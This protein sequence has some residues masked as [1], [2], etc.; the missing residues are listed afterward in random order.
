MTFRFRARRFLKKAFW[1]ILFA[2]Y[3]F[4]SR[5]SLFLVVLFLTQ[6]FLLNA[7]FCPSFLSTILRSVLPGNLTFEAIQISPL[8]WHVD[9][10]GLSIKTPDETE[11]ISASQVRVSVNTI[12]LISHLLKRS[13]E[14]LPVVFE[15]VRV[16]DFFVRLVFEKDKGLEF[17]RAFVHQKV[18]KP[19]KRTTQGTGIRMPLKH[20]IAENGSLFLSFPEWDMTLTGIDTETSMLVSDEPKVFIQTS[21]ASFLKGIVRIH[22]AP[23]VKEIPREIEI[24]E[25]RAKGFDFKHDRFTIEHAEI[26]AKGATVMAKGAFAFSEEANLSYEGTVQVDLEPGSPILESAT[27]GLVNGDFHIEVNGKGDAHNPMFLLALHSSH[28]R[29]RDFVLEDLNLTIHGRKDEAKP[30]CFDGL[31]SSFRFAGG[32]VKISDGWICP[33][34]REHGDLSVSATTKVHLE[35]IQLASLLQGH[36]PDMAK[37]IPDQLDASF[38]VEASSQGKDKRLSLSGSFG[39]KSKAKRLF[40]SQDIALRT[41][42]SVEI[43]DKKRSIEIEKFHL[44]SGEDSLTVKGKVDLETLA[45]NLSLELKK[46]LSPVFSFFGQTGRGLISVSNGYISGSIPEPKVSGRLI[47]KGFDFR[48]VR[49]EEAEGKLLATRTYAVVENLR[50]KS[51]FA[52]L[53]AKNLRIDR[54]LTQNPFI[55]ISEMTAHRI[56][57]DYLQKLPMSLKGIFRLQMRSLAFETRNWFKTMRGEGRLTTPSFQVA[58]KGFRSFSLI[59][60]LDK[61]TIGIQRL[62]CALATGGNIRAKGHISLLSKGTD[63]TVD[64]KGVPIGAF[65]DLSELEGEI[66][67]SFRVLGNIQDPE[68][69]ATATLSGAWLAGISLGDI[70]IEAK[71]KESSN[72]ELSS[73]KFLKKMRLADGS[74]IRYTNGRFDHLFV[75]IDIL[76]LTPQDFFPKLRRRDVTGALSG[77]LEVNMPLDGRPEVVLSSPPGGLV[78]SLLGGEIRYTNTDNLELALNSQGEV[79]ISGLALYDGSSVLR[80]CGVLFGKDGRLNLLLF[81]NTSLAPLRLLRDLISEVHG[82]IDFSGAVEGANIPNGCPLLAGKKAFVVEGEILRPKLKGAILFRDAFFRFRGFSDEVSI[83]SPSPVKVDTRDDGTTKFEVSETVPMRGTIGD[84]HYS[85]SGEFVLKDFTPNSM[86]LN[87][88]GSQIRFA[89]PGSF[90]VVLRPNLRITIPSFAHADKEPGTITGDVEITEGGFHENLDVLSKAFRG[91]VQRRTASKGGLTLQRLP[92]WLKNADLSIALSSKNFLFNSKLPFG[93]VDLSLALD[94]A[95]KGSLNNIQVW[96]RAEI[97]PGGKIVYSLVRRQFEIVK[98]TVDFLGDPKTPSLDVVAKTTINLEGTQIAPTESSRFSTDTIGESE[99]VLVTLALS[100]RYPNL[101]VSL[102]SNASN[103]DATD[104][105][106]LLLTGMTRGQ[107]SGTVSSPFDMGLITEDMTNLLTNALLSPVVDAIRF[108]VSPSGGVSAE[109]HARMGSKVRFQ[110]QVL[111]NQGTS[112]Y[113]ASFNVKLTSRFFLEGRIRAY[114]EQLSGTFT[115]RRHEAKIKYRIPLD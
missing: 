48:N 79:T 47:L 104:L 108:G 27:H 46:D 113:K 22:A 90:F 115:G 44:L 32:R 89:S 13:E 19:E 15:S 78:L 83:S 57:L 69:T 26:K 23:Q 58:K 67:I 114:L 61:D 39:A 101:N 107:S 88:S 105:Q 93:R 62:E 35:A 34:G 2:L 40:S 95:L 109:V 36:S 92:T 72:I 84:G 63:L 8:P 54:F 56:S 71:R 38:V 87:F 14:P 94:L 99:G 81:G 76:D 1:S 21:Y 74:M 59:F 5:L 55:S 50:I 66:N 51:R 45:L 97:T 53:E 33:F 18:D 42:L 77:R 9:V 52:E 41:A 110:T 31:S 70:Q 80:T 43:G 85:L 68:L 82:S 111:E 60:S 98:G 10:L 91:A 102:S 29:I 103:L 49:L 7:S 24:I 12:K 112:T 25:G 73:Q 100:G 16:K 6:Y 37:L 106:L 4:L 65:L 86:S 3:W 30:Y 28:S 96:N 20:I 64:I 11:V 17:L 75:A